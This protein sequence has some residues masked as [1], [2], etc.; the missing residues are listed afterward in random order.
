M[1]RTVPVL[2]VMGTVV[3]G[4]VGSVGVGGAAIRPTSNVALESRPL[5]SR[6]TVGGTKVVATLT[7]DGSEEVQFFTAKVREA[8]TLVVETK[9]CCLRGD[10]WLVTLI[11]QSGGSTVGATDEATA[12]CGSGSIREFSG[13]ATM[14]LRP[15]SVRVLVAYCSGIDEFPAGMTV[16]F[17]YDGPMTVSAS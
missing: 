4:F 10:H 9:D 12:T 8:G 2:F 6:V 11:D 13:R 7:F 16:R 15:G 14:R 17:R 1:R 5:S 3:A